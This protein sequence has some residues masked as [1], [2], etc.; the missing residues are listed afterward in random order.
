MVIMCSAFRLLLQFSDLA[1]GL[2]KK[3]IKA[4]R[5]IQGKYPLESNVHMDRWRFRSDYI[6]GSTS[7]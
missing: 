2:L 7:C 6:H 5:Y 1:K 3:I 4:H